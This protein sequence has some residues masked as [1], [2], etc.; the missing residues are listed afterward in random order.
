MEKKITKREYFAQVKT[1]V[2]A[3]GVANTDEIVAFIDHEIELLNKKSA[4]RTKAEKENDALNVTLIEKITEVL[5][6][7]KKM[8]VTE[9]MKSD[10]GLVEYSN[11]KISA[12]LK[13]MVDNGSV[14]RVTEK[15]KSIFYLA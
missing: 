14:V 10:V 6:G 3:S 9:I 15:G 4:T 5:A 11:Q 12:V 2:Q 13:K 8:T 7:G 1:I